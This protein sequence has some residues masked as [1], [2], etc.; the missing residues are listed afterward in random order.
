MCILQLND[1]YETPWVEYNIPVSTTDHQSIHTQ[2]YL[3]QDLTPGSEYVATM[4][5][6]NIFGAGEITEEF[7]FQTALGLF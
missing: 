1:T 5:A 2:E 3:L 7:L 4:R 6:R